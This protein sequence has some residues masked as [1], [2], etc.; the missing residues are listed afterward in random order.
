MNG[1][2]GAALLA[3]LRA[4]GF[5]PPDYGGR[6][7]INVPATA[8]DVLGVRDASDPVPLADLDPALCDGV[9]QVVMV[10][11][12]GLGYGQLERLC[13]SGETP[14]LASLVERARRRE[15]AQLL[16]CTTIFPSTTAAAV[17]TM[18]TARTPQEH[19]NI[20]YFLWLEEFGRVT[21]MLRWC[22]ADRRRGSYFDDPNLDPRRYVQVPSIHTRL[23]D[24]GG[25]SYVIEPEIFRGQAME[26]MHGVD[27]EF[28]GCAVPSMMGVRLRELL[29]ARPWGGAP[30]LVYAYWEGID[31]V[32]HRLGPRGPEHA[33]EAAAFDLSLGRALRARP[34][35]D[36]LVLLT[37]DHGHAAVEP[38]S[39]LDLH[40]DHELE[41][42]L[43]TP[44]AGE[45]R[46]PFF[47]TDH[48]A[49]VVAHL[50][51]RYP[52]AFF[53]FERDDG[54]EAGLFGRGAPTLVKR[55][56]GEVLGLLDGDRAASI[57]RIEGRPLRQRG[58]HGGMTAD[59]MRIPVL[60][61]RC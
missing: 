8:L 34:P 57:I 19:G 53:T 15:S 6:G 10:L 45:P 4:Q 24:A 28:V 23:R 33:A 41:A 44:L 9:K 51:R 50:R 21:Q 54:I 25:R 55:R 30:A 47:S 35:G 36:T 27:A 7:L 37:A 38:T 5:L 1:A 12:D 18:H 2:G 40:D 46:V 26:R 43:R 11:A 60:A 31:Y 17:T 29:E 42:L 13:E 52:G 59:E 20:A 49:E 48:P 14:F 61:W 56:V 58:S 3:R 22:R 39:F 16:E 32:T